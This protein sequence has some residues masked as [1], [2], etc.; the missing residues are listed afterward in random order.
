MRL[1]AMSIVLA[2]LLACG[3]LGF[4]YGYQNMEE[5]AQEREK[6]LHA[7]VAQVDALYSASR[8]PGRVSA[9]TAIVQEY[10][11]DEQWERVFESIRI[12]DDYAPW[13]CPENG[14]APSPH[15]I[16]YELK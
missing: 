11:T 8:V 9:M 12:L 14:K 16:C 5:S 2:L 4:R 10:F 1:V 15:S 13:Q 7:L 6:I 3:L